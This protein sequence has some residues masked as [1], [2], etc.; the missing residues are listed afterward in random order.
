MIALERSLILHRVWSFDH[1]GLE[2]SEWR[3]LTTVLSA[4]NQFHYCKMCP[5]ASR[6]EPHAS[7]WP[8]SVCMLVDLDLDLVVV[9][10]VVVIVVVVIIV[11][12]WLKKILIL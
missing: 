11:S 8:Y 5:P 3:A 10:V 4:E 2:G 9:I 6:A 1:S 7:A 12:G